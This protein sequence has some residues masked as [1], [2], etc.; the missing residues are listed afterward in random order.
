MNKFFYAFKEVRNNP[1]KLG[2]VMAIF[3]VCLF[4]CSNEND[5][6]ENE[7]KNETNHNYLIKPPIEGESLKLIGIWN[8]NGPYVVSG[9]STNKYGL[10]NGTWELCNDGTYSWIGYNSF[11]YKYSE[12]GKWHYNS[13]NK[14]L[15]TDGPCGIIWQIE[16]ILDSSWVGTLLNSK[17]GTYTYNRKENKEIA[18]GNIRVIDYKKS[19]LII[20]DSITNYLYYAKNLKCGV[21]YGISSNKDVASYKKV[22]TNKVYNDTIAIKDV[23]S[24]RYEIIKG[25]YDVRID[26]LEEN[27][28]YHL[29]GF[30]ELDNGATIYGQ[31]YNAISV[32]P[33]ENSVYMGEEPTFGKVCFWSVGDLGKDWSFISPQQE[34]LNCYQSSNY[35]ETQKAICNLEEGWSIPKETNFRS[36]TNNTNNFNDLNRNIFITE[37]I[38]NNEIG[39]LDLIKFKSRLNGNILYFR[40]KKSIDKFLYWGIQ[41]HLTSY[42]Y[43]INEE[44]NLSGD[45]NLY[46]YNTELGSSKPGSIRI[47]SEDYWIS[48][49]IRPVYEMTV[50]W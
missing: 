37:L 39:T 33:K 32:T 5:S 34:N 11:G 35:E 2:F 1:L 40:F 9:G 38:S 17:E 3:T 29:C 43:W 22:Y 18:V 12:T 7:S 30:I 27:G 31:V 13:E 15:I 16:E 50:T 48:G 44:D 26:N 4:A 47:G 41:G 49:R 46:F 20:K 19:E 21:C 23:I 10:V 24:T 36:F 8:G 42:T 6:L 25:V 14:M 28:K 45:K